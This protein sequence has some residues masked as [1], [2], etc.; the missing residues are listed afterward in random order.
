MSQRAQ[1]RLR[2]EWQAEQAARAESDAAEEAAE[3]ERWAVIN[4]S[5]FEAG[6]PCGDCYEWAEARYGT[7]QEGWVHRWTADDSA[8]GFVTCLH[9]CHEERPYIE[10]PVVT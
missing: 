2:A 4:K 3:R 6:P 9:D 8:A 10:H 5:A 7:W 1:V